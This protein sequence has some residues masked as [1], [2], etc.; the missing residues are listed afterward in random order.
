MTAGTRT[1]DAGA[2][3]S[4]RRDAT[5]EGDAVSLEGPLELRNVALESLAVLV[6]RVVEAVVAADGAAC[7]TIHTV[8]LADELPQ[9]GVVSHSPRESDHQRPVREV[10]LS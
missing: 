6:H 10:H 2:L 9:L 7:G 8:D 3:H 5:R 1:R 4:V